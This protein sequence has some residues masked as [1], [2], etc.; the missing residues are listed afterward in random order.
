MAQ[1]PRYRRRGITLDQQSPLD[2]AASRESIRAA[3]ALEVRLDKISDIAFEKLATKA[4]KEGKL[5]GVQNKVTLEQLQDAID[6]GLDVNQLFEEG[7]TVFSA[8]ARASQ[9]A[10]LE[11]D[12]LNDIQIKFYNI[13]ERIKTDDNINLDQLIVDI[14]SNIQ[15]YANVISKIDPDR[16]IKFQAAASTIGTQTI[17]KASTLIAEK[18][19]ADN[20]V[21]SVATLEF[22]NQYI[23]NLMTTVTDPASF[24]L[25]V[26]ERRSNAYAM[27]RRNPSTYAANVTKFEKNVQDAIKSE[28]ANNLIS[29][30]NITA[31]YTGDYDQF[32]DI[33]EAQG[34]ATTEDKDEIIKLARERLE[35][36]ANV[37]KTAKEA[38]LQIK[39][40]L[41]IENFEKWTNK[42]ISANEFKEILKENN[43]LNVEIIKEINGSKIATTEQDERYNDLELEIITGVINYN[44]I[45]RELAENRI[46]HIQAGQLKSSW[47]TFSV[48][49]KEGQQVI[50]DTFG[51]L[52]PDDVR[53]LGRDDPRKALIARAKIDLLK[54][55]IEARDKKESFNQT[56]AAAE[57]SEKYL[58][59]YLIEAEAKKEDK[60]IAVYAAGN[61]PF[62]KE[63][64]INLT[65]DEI[66]QLKNSRGGS[67]GNAALLIRT[68]N[69]LIK[70]KN[71]IVLTP[72]EGR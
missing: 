58:N 36:L 22:V 54:M 45:N 7:D 47:R 51:I 34:L 39:D 3:Q 57:I 12:L 26:S 8:S 42:E 56:E 44:D 60:A 13:N 21:K 27:F 40:D 20:E 6:T 48:K 1:D 38:E 64:F 71:R 43:L 37:R 29:T 50:R 55:Q 66:K 18:A 35:E 41:F 19:K 15:G 31:F 72:E 59:L 33:L 68:K 10:L 5:Y 69:D 61:I 16:A 24:A 62:D 30:K 25:L 17:N 49:L 32:N 70:L 65:N 67:L 52:D 53:L 23:G 14:N 2:F 46:T 11:Q 9:G 28:I 4:E 63:T